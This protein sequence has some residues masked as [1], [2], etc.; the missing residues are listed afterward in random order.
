[1]LRGLDEAT[2][3]PECG[4]RVSLSIRAASQRNRVVEER[5]SRRMN[6]FTL[7][8][9]LLAGIAFCVLNFKWMRGRDA[10]TVALVA[11]GICLLLAVLSFATFCREFV[12]IKSFTPSI[13][14][15]LL[16]CIAVVFWATLLFGK[17]LI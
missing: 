13:I 9:M 7:S 16:W 2:S 12:A 6:Y 5:L 11:T 8:G 1:M 14:V 17:N 4:T 15:G 10:M 3:C